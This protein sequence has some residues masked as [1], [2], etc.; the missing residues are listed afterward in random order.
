[1]L[2]VSAHTPERPGVATWARGRRGRLAAIRQVMVHR[3]RDQPIS[4]THAPRRSPVSHSRAEVAAVVSASRRGHGAMVWRRRLAAIPQVM[5]HRRPPT[6]RSGVATW[7][8]GQWDQGSP[9]TGRQPPG[10]DPAGDGRPGRN[11]LVSRRGHGAVPNRHHR[12]Q[13]SQLGRDPPEGGRR[14][15]AAYGNA[16]ASRRG[17][18]A[19]VL[20]ITVWRN[21]QAAIRQA[22]APRPQ[23]R[24]SQRNTPA[25]RR[26]HGAM[27]VTIATD[28]RRPLTRNP[29]GDGPRRR[30]RTERPRRRDAGTGRPGRGRDPAGAGPRCPRDVTSRR[31]DAGTGRCWRRW[32]STCVAAWPR[33][34][35]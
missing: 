24:L 33:S 20:T 35:R 8:R 21:R 30:P 7:A 32:R 3:D 16:P 2:A 11:A 15:H 31:R 12:H 18:G 23:G 1:M 9:L 27:V 25:S 34:G 5:A 13:P 19:T 14:C 17:H 6:Q 22:M 26:G 10:R 28:V 4:A 29:A